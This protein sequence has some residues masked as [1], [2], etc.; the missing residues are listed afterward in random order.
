M[1]LTIISIT[2]RPAFLKDL[3]VLSTVHWERDGTAVLLQQQ[4][5]EDRADRHYTE[6]GARE[7]EANLSLPFA[8]VASLTITARSIER[9][10]LR[11]SAQVR[12]S[13]NSQ[14]GKVPPRSTLA[15]IKMISKRVVIMF[16]VTACVCRVWHMS[17]HS[18]AK[19]T[20]FF[21]WGYVR[22]G[23]SGT[24]QVFKNYSDVDEER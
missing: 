14:R 23:T 17:A 4:T 1:T 16:F 18:S 10:S 6:I 12:H 11:F 13:L 15:P 20:K 9:G 19:P 5:K 2:E 7:K 24:S 3:V 21:S 8:F 22:A